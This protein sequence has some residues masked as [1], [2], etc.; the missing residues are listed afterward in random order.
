MQSLKKSTSRTKKITINNLANST[1]SVFFLS[2][3]IITSALIILFIIF[4]QTQ[5]DKPVAW[6]QL[7]KQHIERY[8][9]IQPADVYKLVYQGTF[10]P[11]H[12]GSDSTQILVYLNAELAEIDAD[13]TAS[14]YENIVPSGKKIRLNLKRLKATN[15][16]PQKI[17]QAILN[18]NFGLP[19]DSAKFIRRWAAIEKLV[20]DNR[21]PLP[22]AEFFA[23]SDSVKK[24][25]YPVIHHS[26]QYIQN[27]RPAYRVIERHYLDIISD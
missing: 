14:L 17:V 16:S 2:I 8:P 7:I 5:D 9:A 1:I 20:A 6:E 3:L 11:A 26:A 18:S 27:Y 19:A 15:I 12:L 24:A 10:G 23:F 13:S 25:G 21:L 22:R 4:G